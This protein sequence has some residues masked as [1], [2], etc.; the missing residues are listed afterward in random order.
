MGRH[1]G[2][3]ALAA[4]I[5]RQYPHEAPHC[6]LVPEKPFHAQA[7]LDYVQYCVKHY[8]YCVVVAAEGISDAKGQRLTT[9]HSTDAFGHAQLGG[10]GAGLAAMVRESLGLKAHWALPDYLQRSAGHIRAKVDVDCAKQLGKAGVDALIHGQ[11]NCMLGLERIQNG[12][13]TFKTIAIDLST[14]ANHE[15][16]LHPD[17]LHAENYLLHAHA[18]AYLAPLLQGECHP[19]YQNGL[20]NYFHRDQLKLSTAALVD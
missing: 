13:N 17:W 19:V 4:G 14:C 10:V 15:K 18:K 7:W 5:Q 11:K 8:G 6:I 3:L 12:P 9:S 20:P 1:T 2:W 16:T